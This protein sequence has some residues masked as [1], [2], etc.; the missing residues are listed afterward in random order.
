MTKMREAPEE[1]WLQLQC[2]DG[3]TH[4]WCDH[5]IGEADIVEAGPY[6]RADQTVAERDALR[7]EVKRLR[8]ALEG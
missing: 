2:G 4:T 7:A 3:G 6:V 1:V 5:P 8:A